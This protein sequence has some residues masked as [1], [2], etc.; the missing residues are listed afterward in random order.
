MCSLVV[1]NVSK[2]R[3]VRRAISRSICPSAGEIGLT[4]ACDRGR[5]AH[6]A[7]KGESIHRT[8]N[9]TAVSLD[10]CGAKATMIPAT[11]E[12]TTPPAIRR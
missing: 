10:S 11:H 2:K 12:S 6:C 1:T 7:T 3:Q 5:L 4:L 9:G 8:T